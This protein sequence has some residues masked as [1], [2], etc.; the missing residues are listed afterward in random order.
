MLGL[1]SSIHLPDDGL[2]GIGRRHLSSFASRWLL[3]SF[4]LGTALS[5]AGQS[6][7]PLGSL[8]KQ[9]QG[10]SNQ[11]PA[12]AP[13]TP[14]APGAP[15][16]IPL[17]DVATRAEELSRLLREVSSQLPTR[18]ELDAIKATLDERD[19][20]LHAK[21]EEVQ[22]LLTGTPS[23]LEVREQETY[24]GV[25]SN[26]G[27]A[28]RRQL[29]D[30]ANVAQS[31]MQQLQDLQPRWTLTLE[32]NQ[33]T[34]DLGPTLDVIR[35]AVKSIQT[36]KAQAQDLLRVIVNLQ[37]RAANQ[38][39]LAL[40]TV[41]RLA[42]ARKEVAGRIFRRDSL[43][44]WQIFRRRE[45][46]GESRDFFGDT[47]ARVISIELFTRNNEGIFLAL[48]AIFALWLFAAFRLSR[49]TRGVQP[50]DEIQAQAI[51]ILQHWFA[52][53]LLWPLML[54]FL[55]APLAP[56]P[57]IGAAIVLS[58]FSII[59]LL[60]RLI[61]PGI[62]RS[63]YCLVVVYAFNA[64]LSWVTLSPATKRELLF[65]VFTAAVVA[66]S[67]LLR[68]QRV[69]EIEQRG[70]RHRFVVLAS[71]V[72]VGVLA[73][74]Q[75]CNLFGYY[76]LAQ[77]LTVLSLYSTFFALAIFTATRVFNLVLV[78]ALSVPAAERLALVRLHRA[79]IARWAPRIMQ[80]IGVLLWLG[81]FLGLMGARS[82]IND[83][84]ADVL[85]FSLAGP[86]SSVTLGGILGLFAILLAGYAI[87]SAIR[88]ILREELLKRLHLR[89]GVPELISTTLHYLLLLMVFLFAVNT[90]GIALNKFTVLTGALGVGVGF[91][92]QNIINNFVSGLILQF[93]RPIRIGD[94]VDLGAGVSGPVTRIGIRS[95]TVQTWQ[96]AE[97]IVPNSSFISGNVTNW[98]LSESKRRLELPVGVAYGSDT[99]LVKELLER[100]AI[101]HADVLTSPAPEAFFMGFGQS[102]LDF[103]LR[104][105]VMQ[106]SNTAKVKSEVALE[107]MRLLAEAGIEIPFPQHD[108]RLRSVDAEAAAAL[109]G[110][111]TERE[112]R[113]EDL[114][115]RIRSAK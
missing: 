15:T 90:G 108:L 65:V 79:D 49:A 67:W 94:V 17:P 98:T 70:G 40:D 32:E 36:T 20:S 43:P 16:A 22:A 88:F 33:H 50:T 71:R 1:P 3:L 6:V 107:V 45:Q 86:A 13:A 61:D 51:E 12:P 77:Y 59:T 31:A 81:A 115:P 78:A 10:Q 9:N 39:Q 52:F 105:W 14:S 84:I 27:A 73:L 2:C 97:V 38:H 63:L 4:V 46:V 110:D 19:D 80:W 56:L 75:I 99:K 48:G 87:A 95:S 18:D 112:E 7:N 5:A 23:A 89:R 28:M 109:A 11:K 100:P 113:S 111:G 83:F 37:V 101:Q 114:R 35:D 26:E 8:L 42:Q 72:A 54:A 53:A 66:F 60:P 55:L 29:L 85:R 64:T 76:G 96:G 58:F 47:G 93:E 103:E 74:G 34:P 82:T 30:W 44:L 24:W 102:S 92:L 68:P 21:H 57:L 25:F 106:E 69:A 62:R 91:G 41:T 104:F